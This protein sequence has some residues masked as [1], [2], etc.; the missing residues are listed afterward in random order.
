MADPSIK[1]FGRTIADYSDSPAFLI[2]DAC[3]CD[4]KVSFFFFYFFLMLFVAVMIKS[5]DLLSVRLV[6]RVA[7]CFL[8]V[9]LGFLPSWVDMNWMVLGFLLG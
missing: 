1:L 9:F 7:S 5:T 4:V 2:G 3:G 6:L 8:L